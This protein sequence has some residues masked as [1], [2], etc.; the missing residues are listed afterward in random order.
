MYTNAAYPSNS[1]SDYFLPMMNGCS[2]L[3][4]IL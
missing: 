2:I 3:G 4:A 1:I